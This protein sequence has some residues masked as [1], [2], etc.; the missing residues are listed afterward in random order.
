MTL[1][2]AVPPLGDTQVLP[3]HRTMRESLCCA[4]APTELQESETLC[5]CHLFKCSPSLPDSGELSG[6]SQEQGRWFL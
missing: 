2:M 5:S 6:C 1:A 3:K 4:N